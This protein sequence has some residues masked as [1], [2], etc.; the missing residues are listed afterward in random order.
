MPVWQTIRQTFFLAGVL[1]VPV[2][3]DRVGHLDQ[4]RPVFEQFQ[5]F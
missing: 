1:F 4:P 2:L 3:V 5:Q